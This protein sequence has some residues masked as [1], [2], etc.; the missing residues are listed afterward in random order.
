MLSCTLCESVAQGTRFAKEHVPNETIVIGAG[1][2]KAF[3]L[4]LA[5]ELLPMLA[6][7][8]SA[9]S[10]DRLDL[11]YDFLEFFYPLFD[12]S[13]NM[14]FPP[15]EDV[16]GM[17]DTA[18]AYA[19]IRGRSRGYRWRKGRVS[20]T[21]RRF[22]RLLGEFL[23]SYQEPY[24]KGADSTLSALRAF[25][26]TRG[27]NIVYVTFNY[28]LLLETALS[29]EGMPYT[30]TLDQT[31]RRIVVLKPHGSVNWFVK[32]EGKVPRG[33]MKWIHLGTNIAVC[34]TL[35]PRQL[36]FSKTKW[37]DAAI[38]APT[39][40]KQI[41]IEELKRIWTSFSSSITAAAKL[42]IIGYSLPSA[43][44]LARLVLHRAGPRHSRSKKIFIVNPDDVEQTYRQAISPDC[45]FIKAR[46][47]DWV[48][49]A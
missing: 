27:N 48:T 31:Q 29:L 42:T 20:D 34:E 22:N 30:Y 19:E 23:W 5:D 26:R 16:L 10:V 17:L 15:A 25:V 11:I 45:I 44:R 38:I 7:W 41:E 6:E 47:Q 36:K 12:R 24:A 33:Y 32:H 49:C 1:L 3:G 8:H 13:T 21:S 40:N 28:D 14:H 43:D 39:P 18:A 2:S 35:D 4:P 9:R 46:F 37:K